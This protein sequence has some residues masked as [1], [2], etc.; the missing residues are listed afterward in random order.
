MNGDREK[1]LAAGMDDYI[2]KPINPQELRAV[3]ERTT[4]AAKSSFAL[5]PVAQP[6]EG[7]DVFNVDAALDQLESD[8]DLLRQIIQLFVDQYPKLLEET[9]QAFSRS[10]CSSLTAIAHTLASSAGQ[11]GAQRASAA[12]RNLEQLGCQGNLSDVPQAIAKLE[13][14]LLLLNSAISDP[15][16]SPQRTHDLLAPR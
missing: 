16:N 5:D 13:S 9:R 7:V 8:K 15:T 3:M 14:E 1:C 6:T 2:S 10:D 11:L 12:A 4:P